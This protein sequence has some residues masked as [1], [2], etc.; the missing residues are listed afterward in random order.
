M[1]KPDRLLIVGC[2]A[3][4]LMLASTTAVLGSCLTPRDE[5]SVAAASLQRQEQLLDD[6]QNAVREAR[7]ELS[8]KQA[9]LA[10]CESETVPVGTGSAEDLHTPERGLQRTPVSS[11]QPAMQPLDVRRLR[12]GQSSTQDD[13]AAIYGER[14]WRANS[15][16]TDAACKCVR[17]GRVHRRM[18]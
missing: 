17:M 16:F 6:V 7:R 3:A 10:E 1:W 8:S 4:E 2:L 18:R 12:G 5:V 11:E 14:C 13:E 9:Q 15:S